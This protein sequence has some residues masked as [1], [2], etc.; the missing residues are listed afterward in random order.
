MLV[1]LMRISSPSFAVVPTVGKALQGSGVDVVELVAALAVAGDQ[2]RPDQYLQV[3]GDRL[4]GR[5]ELVLHGQ[6]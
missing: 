1:T 3:L 2:A 4:P 5:A 6:S